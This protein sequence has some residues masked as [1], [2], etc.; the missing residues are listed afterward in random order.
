MASEGRTVREIGLEV[1]I[2]KDTVSRYGRRSGNGRSTRPVTEEWR[3]GSPVR[4]RP[5][6]PDR[7]VECLCYTLPSI[8]EG[9]L[10][11]DEDGIYDIIPRIMKILGRSGLSVPEVRILC[12][13]TI[14]RSLRMTDI[15]TMSG[16]SSGDSV[17]ACES[18]EKM[19]LAEIRC[20]KDLGRGKPYRVVS[21][22]G[23]VRS[24][25]DVLEERM[26]EERRILSE[27]EDALG[28]GNRRTD[29]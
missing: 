1:G 6:I 23:G 11:T 5:L 8:P 13:L 2:S 18:L 20:G 21:L 10:R 9:Q 14:H 3:P 16:M 29:N 7:D 28:D 15:S 17:V 26:A 22:K 19:G 24:L 27:L 12:L 25:F 4:D